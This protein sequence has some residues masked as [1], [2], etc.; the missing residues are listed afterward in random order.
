MPRTINYS[1]VRKLHESGLPFDKIARKLKCSTHGVKYALQRM[2]IWHPRPGWKCQ[3]IDLVIETVNELARIL[4][5]SPASVIARYRNA[6]KE[7][8]G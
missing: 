1:R 4:G 6:I 7:G 8:M 2:G 5:R 3:E